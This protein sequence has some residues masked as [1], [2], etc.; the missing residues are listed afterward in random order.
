M[1]LDYQYQHHPSDSRIEVKYDSELQVM[2]IS[3]TNA[4]GGASNI[5]LW[6]KDAMQVVLR[7][8]EMM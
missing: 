3:V 8:L 5:L 1:N 4:S 6:R 7:M 2:E